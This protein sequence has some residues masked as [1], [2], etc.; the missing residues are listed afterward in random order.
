MNDELRARRQRHQKVHSLTIKPA[1]GGFIVS[2]IDYIDNS[3][4]P[5]QFAGDPSH[6]AVF[7]SIEEMTAFLAELLTC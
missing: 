3:H 6:D 4:M 1:Q 2:W 5:A 7:M